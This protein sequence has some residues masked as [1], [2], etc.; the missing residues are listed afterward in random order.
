MIKK[1]RVFAIYLVLAIF[2]CSEEDAEPTLPNSDFSIVEPR[3]INGNAHIFDREDEVQFE[4]L[5]SNAIRY[6]WKFGDGEVSSLKNPKH[7]FSEVG[8]YEVKLTAYSGVGA[9]S[10]SSLLI[11]IARR[12]LTELWIVSSQVDLPSRAFMF[13]GESDN[14]ENSYL[15]SLPNSFGNSQL[16]F[17][18]P[19]N[20]NENFTDSDWFLMLIKDNPP[21]SSFDITDELIFGSTFNPLISTAI[22]DGKEGQFVLKEG[23]NINGENAGDIEFRIH[24]EL[25]EF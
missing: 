13:L 14:L 8:E 10:E 3:F 11:V 6:E 15:I 9:S 1:K 21:L 7:R 20:L 4:N 17:G 23:K 22:Y 18:G 2:S 12:K 25:R 24:F 19:I 16:P 5:S